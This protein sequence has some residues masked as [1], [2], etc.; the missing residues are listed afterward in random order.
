MEKPQSRY[1]T[2]KAIEG[3]S[4]EL[5]FDKSIDSQDWEWVI[6]NENDIEKYINRYNKEVDEDKKFALMEIIIQATEDQETDFLFQKYSD[7]ILKLLND[8]FKIH[9]HSI[10]Y[11]SSFSIKNLENC[12]KISNLMRKIW[13]EKQN[14]KI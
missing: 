9:E 1:V 11:W 14:K 7:I 3:L 4:N 8:N 12:W 13:T 6:G 10:Y 5:D 2:K